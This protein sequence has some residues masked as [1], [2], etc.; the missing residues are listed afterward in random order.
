MNIQDFQPLAG[1]S[2]VKMDRLL[3]ANTGPIV[4]PDSLAAR[5]VFIG[6]VV[7]SKLSE[8]DARVIG[9]DDIN[10]MRVLLADHVGV[11][12]QD[13]YWI[14]PNSYARDPRAKKKRFDTPFLC[15][16]PADFRFDLHDIGTEEVP[17]CR[18]CG[19][20]KSSIS[21]NN[22]YMAH[23]HG[24]GWYCPRC[25]RTPT[26]NKIDPREIVVNKGYDT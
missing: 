3:G 23:H 26:G 13:D 18:F 21:G 11:N 25:N 15:L 8:R 22:V 10:G 17:R 2:L 16:L 6:T 9:T 12:L 7:K 20:A 1:K 19:P 5:P 4:I 24:H 14:V